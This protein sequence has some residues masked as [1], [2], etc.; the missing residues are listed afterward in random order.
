MKSEFLISLRDFI[1]HL[2]LIVVAGGL[3]YIFLCLPLIIFSWIFSNWSL[4][5][6]IDIWFFLKW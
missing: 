3:Y 4:R 2:S 6:C 5:E 1:L